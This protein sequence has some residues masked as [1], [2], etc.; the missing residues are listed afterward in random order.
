VNAPNTAIVAAKGRQDQLRQLFEKA[1]PSI[2]AVIPR[3]LTADRILKITLAATSRTPALLECSPDSILLAV[4]QAAQLGLEPNTPLGL[5]YLVP[6]ENKRLRRKEAQFIPGYRGLIRLAIQSGEIKSI[7]A[8]AVHAL[9]RWEVEYGL[10]QRLVH[11]PF[12]PTAQA[13]LPRDEDAAVDD[14]VPPDPDAGGPDFLPSAGP[15]VAVYAVAEFKAGGRVFEF[16][17]RA[18]VEAIR[19]RSRAANSG[20][21]VTDYEEMAKK[22]VIRR[23]CKTL[24]LATEQ[25]ASALEHQARAESGQGPDFSDIIDVIPSGELAEP[26]PEPKKGAAA[27]KAQLKAVAPS[28]DDL[29]PADMPTNREPGSEG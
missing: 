14:D 23:L 26:K 8:R 11:V 15:M 2:A 7:Y 17:T 4:M 6:Y 20:P 10:D 13:Q 9:D 27:L 12:M 1:K 21:W 5:S 18:D 19:R 28:P 29:P 16:M 22:T 25:L 24:P 3:H